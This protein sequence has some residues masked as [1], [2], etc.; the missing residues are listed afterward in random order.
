MVELEFMPA[1]L[2]RMVG[3]TLNKSPAPIIYSVIKIIK[4]IIIHP[5]I[6]LCLSVLQEVGERRSFQD[7]SGAPG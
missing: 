1:D 4:V 6:S 7:V 2:G 3:H 5:L